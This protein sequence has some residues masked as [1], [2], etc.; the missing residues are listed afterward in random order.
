[1]KS[2]TTGLIALMAIAALTMSSIGVSLA[3]EVKMGETKIKTVMVETTEL[4]GINGEIT[5]VLLNM[6]ITIVNNNSV[7]VY[8]QIVRYDVSLELEETPM[9]ILE[10][11]LRDVELP[12]KEISVI[13]VEREITDKTIIQKLTTE[14]QKINVGYNLDM[15]AMEEQ[16][17]ASGFCEI[18]TIYGSGV[19]ESLWAPSLAVTPTSSQT[20]TPSPIP[21]PTP[22]TLMTPP[23][24]PTEAPTAIPAA[25]VPEK[26]IP[27]FE[28]VFAIAGLLAVAYLVKRRG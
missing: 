26:G 10:G 18:N 25:E 7:T 9:T 27:G 24:S 28:A 6:S 23:P 8:G 22:T 13:R 19:W 16:W 4:E 14:R 5:A 11:S 15:R 21:T 2:K 1:M 3:D 12:P 17:L 20:P